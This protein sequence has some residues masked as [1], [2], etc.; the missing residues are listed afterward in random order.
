MG[1][2][3]ASIPLGSALGIALGGVIATYLGWRH[4]FGLVAIPGFIVGILFFFIMD[5]KTVALTKKS[6]VAEAGSSQTRMSAKEIAIQIAKT[7]TLYFA[8]LGFAAMVF[9]TS[10]LVLFLP[11]YFNR[12]AGVSPA[13]AG[14]MAS[15]V[16]VLAVVGTPLGGH[17]ADL[18]LKKRK[19]ARLLLGSISAIVSAVFLFVA[20][21]MPVGTIQYITFL[22]TGIS[23]TAFIPAVSA[24][25][26]DVVHP[27]LRAITIS[28]V[29]IV[30][31]LLGTSLG[32]IV[33]G[34]ISDTHGIQTAFMVL[35]AFLAMAAM[36]FFAGSFFFNKDF[37]KVEKVGLQME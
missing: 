20:I 37:D 27:G 26:Q 17:L 2:W 9:A 1:I 28:L 8:Y 18:W 15:A 11:T 7:P 29:V 24:A 32:P 16:M 23:I 10:S 5:Y 21:S 30:Q 12:V 3:N 4:A 25:M 14:M 33:V 35:P 31:H 13:Q 22:F 6:E 19:N 36:L 34:S